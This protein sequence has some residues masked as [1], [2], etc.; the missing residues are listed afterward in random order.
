MPTIKEYSLNDP[1]QESRDLAFWASK[2]IEERLDG[3]QA[4]R[5]SWEKL[6]GDENDRVEGLRGSVRIVERP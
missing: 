2:T 5:R 3:L 1:D 4:I 6:N